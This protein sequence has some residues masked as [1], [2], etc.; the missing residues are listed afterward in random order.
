MW[1]I[2]WTLKLFIQNRLLVALVCAA[3]NGLAHNPYESGWILGVVWP[4]FVYS[5]CFLEWEKKSKGKAI[6]V[7]AM[8]HTFY[9]MVPGGCRLIVILAG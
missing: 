1:A 6:V 5:L 9:N 2:L 7:T 4:F 3:I 8:V